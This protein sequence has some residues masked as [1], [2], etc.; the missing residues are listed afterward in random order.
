MRPVTFEFPL[1]AMDYGNDSFGYDE[2]CAM[3]DESTQCTIVLPE[4]GLGYGP[5]VPFLVCRFALWF[6]INEGLNTESKQSKHNNVS[7]TPTL[8][9]YQPRALYAVASHLSPGDR[10]LV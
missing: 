2:L 1:K 8:G 9:L 5:V 3:F 4:E 6:R 7:G 10:G